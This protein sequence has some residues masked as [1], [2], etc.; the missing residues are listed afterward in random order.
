MEQFGDLY[1]DDLSGVEWISGTEFIA[2]GEGKDI[3]VYSSKGKK[4]SSI[5][6]NDVNAALTG[7][8]VDSLKSIRPLGWTSTSSFA[9]KS[10]KAVIE[11]N[12]KKKTATKLY[13]LPAEAANLTFSEAS[14]AMAYTIN[15]DV[16]VTTE[17]GQK[18]LTSLPEGVSAGIAIH[19]SEF[20]IVNGLFWSEKGDAL[21]FYQMDET[22]VT[23]YPLANYESV[24]GKV[25]LIKYPMAGQNSHHAKVGV[26]HLGME[27][28]V[29]LQTKE[30][31]DHYLTNFTF[32]PSS[33]IVYLAELNRD[34]NRM[35]L[36]T[37]DAK[38]GAFLKT[39][40]EETDAEYVEPE[41]APYFIKDGEEFLW[42]SERDGFNH[43][44]RYS[45][46]GD[47]INLVTSGKE[48]VKSLIGTMDGDK[49]VLVEMTTDLMAEKIVKF[50]LDGK[51]EKQINEK[52]GS[53]SVY[54][55]DD[56]NMITKRQA[57][58]IGSEV[59]IRNASGKLIKTLKTSVNPLTEY[60]I[61][62]VQTPVIT[63]DDGTLLQCRIIKPYDF[64]PKEE[65][66]VLVYVYGGP[67][68]QLITENY[69]YGA[70]MWMYH[71]ANRGYIIFTVD[72]RGSANRG[73]EFEQAIFRNLGTVELDDQIAGVKYLKTLNYVDG[74]HIA[75]H[76]WS[77]GG[78]MTTSLM[79][80]HPD[81]FT[82]GVAGG[83]VTDWDLYEVMYGERYMDTPEQNP[84]GYEA[85]DLK[86]HV[87]NLEG[88]LLLIHG[89]DDDVVVPQHSYTLIE[90]FVDA[91]KQVDFFVYPGH[92]HNVR[93]KDRVHLMTKVLDY[94]E[95]HNQVE[96]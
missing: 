80:K 66:P 64:D 28:P 94:V 43:L 13:D 72:G 62:E 45:K 95:M 78:F 67:H 33:S 20:G 61:G 57:R 23:D 87:S 16:Y 65:Y 60:Q 38:T 91:Q 18:R 35:M 89:L 93:G 52:P 48:A 40:F 58:D 69:R 84:A 9:A 3:D 51:T 39:L 42:F 46:N 12:I 24:P 63:A 10:G 75:V 29:Y 88:K 79:L 54:L 26:Y 7:I 11:Y 19:R 44:Y 41:H 82:V 14:K 31:L 21:G 71:M 27:G 17:D 56:G 2:K 81:V 85:A 96:E 15:R 34:Q 30:P 37:Y 1:P 49:S 4:T 55:S 53:F 22:M 59:L 70:S 83:P 25:N 77:Y 6:L 74:D 68:A 8:E 50:S 5:T 73:I 36:N 32:D 90:A 76:G 86:N 92:K 47:L